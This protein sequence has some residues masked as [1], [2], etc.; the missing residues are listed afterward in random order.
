[1]GLDV[2]AS[3]GAG[4]AAAPVAV[5]SR[6]LIA[7]RVTIPPDRC[8]SHHRPS[9]NRS[10]FSLSALQPSLDCR[11]RQT[12]CHH[13]RRPSQLLSANSPPNALQPPPPSPVAPPPR[14]SAPVPKGPALRGW[15]AIS[16]ARLSQALAVALPPRPRGRVSPVH[17]DAPMRRPN[18]PNAR[19]TDHRSSMSTA[20]LFSEAGIEWWRQIVSAWSPSRAVT[21][22]CSSSTATPET[23][24]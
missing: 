12:P 11:R 22:T 5:P 7:S 1:M 13:C 14:A 21:Q 6:V 19:A 17:G 9:Y 2:F 16:G 3:A 15:L 18:A 24:P 8:L 20:I 23:G 10:P 4:A